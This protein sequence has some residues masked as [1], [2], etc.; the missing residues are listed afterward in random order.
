[1]NQF[2][3]RIKTTLIKTAASINDDAANSADHIE[4][5]KMLNMMQRYIKLEPFLLNTN[6]EEFNEII[7]PILFKQLTAYGQDVEAINQLNNIK[8]VLNSQKYEKVE[9]SQAKNWDK[10]YLENKNVK[11]YTDSVN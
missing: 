8:G 2:L 5:I 7:Y 10:Q 6:L 1:M 9:I 11:N 3:K 4:D